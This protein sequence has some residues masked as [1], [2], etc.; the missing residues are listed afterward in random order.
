MAWPDHGV[1]K[2]PAPCIQGIKD[3]G[4]E[5]DIH[6]SRHKHRPPIIVHCSAGEL[7]PCAPHILVF[8]H[9]TSQI[10]FIIFSSHL[11]NSIYISVRGV[12]IYSNDSRYVIYRT[13]GRPVEVYN[14]VHRIGIDVDKVLL[15]SRAQHNVIDR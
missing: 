6:E 15:F 13:L 2:D 7:G 11:E 3:I 14:Y 9:I 10:S 1:P 5:L 12:R 4:R 8:P